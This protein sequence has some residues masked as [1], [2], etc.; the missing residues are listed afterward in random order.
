M[1]SSS[2]LFYFLIGNCN[3]HKKIGSYI[4]NKIDNKNIDNIKFTCDEIF[5][6]NSE[7]PPKSTKNKT[8]TEKYIILYTIKNSIFFYLAVVLKNSLYS[9]HENL[10]YE[11]F[12][13]IENSGIR[14]LV[15][16]NGELS[17][18]GKQNLKFC[19]EQDLEENKKALQNQNENSTNNTNINNSL[20]D[21]YE[22]KNYVSKLSLLN[23]EIND[24]QND[25]KQSMKNIIGNVNEMQ[26]LDEKSSKIKD[27][28][29]QFQK[30]A[31]ILQRKVRCRKILYITIIISII[32][33]III[34]VLFFI[35]K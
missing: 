25:V 23:N 7:N 13:D 4:D 31:S 16:K 28:S 10:I 19:I 8:E 30:D 12:D 11:L 3:T 15:D 35:F 14:K 22:D 9:E 34:I 6:K 26:E 21:Y 5:L 32:L 1:L 24:I 27:I 17:F 20:N 2:S 29:F 33:V 18:I